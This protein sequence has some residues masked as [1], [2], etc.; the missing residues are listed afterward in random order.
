MT[1]TAIP[2]PE[3]EDTRILPPTTGPL[4][5]IHHWLN[6]I[7]PKTRR[8]DRLISC[9]QFRLAHGRWP[10]HRATLQD[11][12]LALKVGDEILSRDRVRTTDKELAK[13]FI[14]EHAGPGLAVPTIAVLHSKKEAAGYAF[15]SRCVIKPTHSSGSIIIRRNGEALNLNRILGWFDHN[16]YRVWREANYRDLPPKVIVEPVLFD[17]DPNTELKVFCYRGRVKCIK[18]Y[19]GAPVNTTS[20]LFTADWQPLHATLGTPVSPEVRARPEI[21]ERIVAIAEALAAPFS[22][23]RVDFYWQGTELFVGELT[24][25]DHNATGQFFPLEETDRI[26]RIILEPA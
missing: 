21:L 17:A 1:S 5:S 14:E 2:E 26:S 4:W 13:H 10:G 9:L 7:T 18:C 16:Y 22:L 3:P 15:P 8:F 12:L 23:V 11:A 19:L 6:G 25:I 24:H 20:M